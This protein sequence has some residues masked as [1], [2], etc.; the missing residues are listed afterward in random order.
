MIH[1][2]ICIPSTCQ[3]H[4]AEVI[5]SGLLDLFVDIGVLQVEIKE[6]DCYFEVDSGLSTGQLIYG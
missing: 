6:K 5:L 4:D 3:P 2:A 1:W